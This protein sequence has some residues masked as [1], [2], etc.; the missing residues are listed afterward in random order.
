MENTKDISKRWL[1]LAIGVFTMLFAGVLYSWSILKVPFSSVGELGYSDSALALNY[2]LTMCFFCVGG[3]IS[4]V[5]V[6]KIG[7]KFTVAFSGILA[8]IGYILC[9]LL[10]K[11]SLWALYVVYSFMGGIG[12]GMAY[13]AIISTVNSWFPDK[14]GLSFG[15]LMMGFGASTLVLGNIADTMFM[16]LGWRK[17]YVIIGTALGLVIVMS[18][19]L[20]KKPS[21][22]LVFPQAKNKSK[23]NNKTFETVDFKPMEMLKRFTFWRAFLFLVFITAVGNS[24]IGF[25]KQLALSVGAEPALATTLVGV[26]AVFNG[27]GRIISGA[28]FDLK[29]CKYVMF[30][31]NILTIIAACVMLLAVNMASLPLCIVGLCLTGMSYGTSPTISSSFTSTFYGTKYFSSNLSLMNC[32]LMGAAMIAS[33]CTSLVESSGGYN[34]SFVLLLVLALVALGLNI[35]IKKP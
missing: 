31:A 24:V 6:R 13:I 17:T 2:T 29:G 33:V 27:L 26:V 21:E 7:H 20:V 9:A 34:V 12:I 11:E 28:V 23:N 10:V 8:G 25:A 14:R 18:A 16:S 22:S 5:L 4:G 35:S 19:F 1:I 30:S 3:L 32:D 15:A